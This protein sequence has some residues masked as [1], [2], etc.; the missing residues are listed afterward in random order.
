MK[1]DSP[2]FDVTKR[3]QER[4]FK[5]SLERRRNLSEGE[6][7]LIKNYEKVKKS[8]LNSL[9]RKGLSWQDKVKNDPKLFRYR[10]FI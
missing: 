10:K 2:Y 3:I 1:K 9:S 4:P 8:R 6:K 5:F 7:R